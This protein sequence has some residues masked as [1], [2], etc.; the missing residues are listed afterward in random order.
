MLACNSALIH[1]SCGSGPKV[2]Y[3]LLYGVVLAAIAVY[4]NS[5]TRREA[6]GLLL[7]GSEVLAT[8]GATGPMTEADSLLYTSGLDIKKLLFSSR[9]LGAQVYPEEKKETLQSDLCH[10]KVNLTKGP[11]PR[12]DAYSMRTKL[13]FSPLIFDSSK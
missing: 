7:P 3:F 12:I 8:I 9:K 1:P 5:I 13:G 4:Q 11:I 2:E 10:K 6:C